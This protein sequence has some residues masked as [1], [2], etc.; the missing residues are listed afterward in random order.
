MFRP[1][2]RTF[3]V[4]LIYAALLLDNVLLTVIVPILPD[5]LAELRAT[6]DSAQSIGQYVPRPFLDASVGLHYVPTA[7]NAS[8]AATAAAR[9]IR[10]SDENGAIGVLLATKAVVQLLVTPFVGNCAQRLGYRLP[11]VLGTACLLV[12]SIGECEKA[13]TYVRTAP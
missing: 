7:L 9:G 8:T 10:L 11:I 2:G 12:A 3:T 5:Y 13:C 6:A 1:A 4:V